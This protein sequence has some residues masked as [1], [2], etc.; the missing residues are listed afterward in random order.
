MASTRSHSVLARQVQTGIRS[1]VVICVLLGVAN[2]AAFA[3]QYPFLPVPGAPKG[4]TALFQDSRGRLWL[5]GPQPAC[6]DGTRFFFLRGYG[7]PLADARAFSEDAGG[8]IWIGADTGVYRFANGRVE[9][10]SKGPAV[11][12][13][14]ATAGLAVAA[15]G[16]PGGGNNASPYR[17]QR[18]G[19][20]WR[21]KR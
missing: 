20:R 13:I 15:M 14:A 18:A 7:F 3:Q 2:S 4:V 16:P 21:L 12:V 5:G 19:D 17:I 8:A 6:F 9:E 10:V 1:C 11:G